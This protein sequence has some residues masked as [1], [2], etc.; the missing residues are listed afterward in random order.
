MN[1]FSL[2]ITNKMK[3]KNF[4]EL[5]YLLWRTVGVYFW[6]PFMLKSP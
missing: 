1:D 6:L 2:N 5:E 4:R 3:I